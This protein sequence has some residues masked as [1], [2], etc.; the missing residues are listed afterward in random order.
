[1]TQI[2]RCGLGLF[3]LLA[4]CAATGTKEKPAAALPATGVTSV[5]R[6]GDDASYRAG[7]ALRFA[8]NGD[9]T[10]TDLNT[11]LAWIKSGRGECDTDPPTPS[12]DDGGW[13]K[14]D[15]TNAVLYCE[16]LQ[17][18][19]HRDWRLPN[20]KELV[21]ILDLSR[22]DPAAD[23]AFFPDTR[24]DFYWTSTPFTYDPAHA[25]YVYFNLGY[26]NHASM[27]RYLFVRPVRGP[28]RD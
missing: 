14:Y 1:M 17:F 10:V 3:I 26:V 27:D 12:R 7:A 2:A 5:V 25:W 28:D 23:P 22:T 6:E 21:S 19:G 20:Y 9:G 13:R 8:D 16:R 4:G 24:S 18:A 15:W 11:G